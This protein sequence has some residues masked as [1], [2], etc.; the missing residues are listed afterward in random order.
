MKQRILQ[1]LFWLFY[2]C[3]DCPVEEGEVQYHTDMYG[4]PSKGYHFYKEPCKYIRGSRVTWF[5]R[6]Q[7]QYFFS[8]FHHAWVRYLLILNDL[9][10]KQKIIFSF[11]GNSEI[12]NECYY[13][14]AME[15]KDLKLETGMR[16]AH[17]QLQK[18]KNHYNR[19]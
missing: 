10:L 8:S 9:K 14:K 2:R 15:F 12:Y 16:T 5:S 19:R 4:S 11:E 1:S 6:T 18:E 13:N 3:R 17:H 7:M